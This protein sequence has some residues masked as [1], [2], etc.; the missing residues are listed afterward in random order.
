MTAPGHKLGISLYS[1]SMINPIFGLGLVLVSLL[2]ATA[3]LDADPIEV[4]QGVECGLGKSF[5]MG[6]RAALREAVG[7]GL[8]VFRGLIDTRD[9]LSFHQD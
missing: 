1:T 4:P 3:D 7:D 8:M 5:H 2:P 6:R 9:Y